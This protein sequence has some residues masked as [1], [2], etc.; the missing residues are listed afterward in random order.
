MDSIRGYWQVPLTEKSQE[1]TTFIT[2][3]GRYKYL[4][5]PM[6]LNSTGDRY[7]LLMDAAVDGLANQKKVV[8]DMIFSYTQRI[9]KS[10]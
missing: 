7:N 1:L 9:L 4:L 6:G 10:M 3:W 2:P 8:D 5:A